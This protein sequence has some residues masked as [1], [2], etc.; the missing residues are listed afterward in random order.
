MQDLAV[1]LGV[2]SPA[3]RL[4]R[5]PHVDAASGKQVPPL[6]I[7]DKAEELTRG[8]ARRLADEPYLVVI[9]GEYGPCVLDELVNECAAQNLPGCIDVWHVMYE[10][11]VLQNFDNEAL[12]FE[13]PAGAFRNGWCA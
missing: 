9:G 5:E 3:L 13:S 10:Q 8:S 11:V 1:V 7:A 4:V 12:G 2:A 6:G